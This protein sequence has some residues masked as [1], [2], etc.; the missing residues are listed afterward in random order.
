[1]LVEQL[2]EIA[3]AGQQLAEQHSNLPGCALRSQSRH[4]I[5]TAG[6]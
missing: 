3:F 5:D 6:V 1:M 2:E 4:Q